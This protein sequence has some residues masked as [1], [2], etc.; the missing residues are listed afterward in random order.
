MP[1]SHNQELDSKDLAQ[2]QE[3]SELLQRLFEAEDKILSKI[4]ES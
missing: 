4:K 2:L 3:I 1:I